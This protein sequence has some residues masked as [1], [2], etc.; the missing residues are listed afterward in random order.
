M[1]YLVIAF[2]TRE[3]G[4]Q[5]AR[6]SR[7]FENESEA[8]L[9]ADIVRVTWVDPNI[10]VEVREGGGS[11]NE[12]IVVYTNAPPAYDYH[13]V[14]VVNAEYA[15]YTG[16]G[17]SHPIFR[18]ILIHG[19]DEREKEYRRDYQ[20]G[21]YASGMYS[22]LTED[23]FNR[24]IENEMIEIIDEID[25]PPPS[26]SGALCPDCYCPASIDD[27]GTTCSQCGRGIIIGSSFGDQS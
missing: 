27:V 25:V 24:G 13:Y 21:R 18:K 1:A 3:D 20:C 8:S 6:Y 7:E 19:R 22:S 15:R 16:N 10:T 12:G 9:H 17:G 4:S 11:K 14:E 23:E 5:E 2:S 26:L